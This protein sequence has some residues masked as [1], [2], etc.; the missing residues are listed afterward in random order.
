MSEPVD[1][2]AGWVSVGEIKSLASSGRLHAC[3]EVRVRYTVMEL[4]T[5]LQLSCVVGPSLGSS[6]VLH[7]K[8]KSNLK[9]FQT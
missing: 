4:P 8:S 9:S 3:V 7:C 1:Q 6:T 2:I 5:V